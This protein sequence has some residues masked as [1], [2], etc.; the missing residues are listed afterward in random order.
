MKNKEKL[1]FIIFCSYLILILSVSSY[2]SLKI[3]TSDKLSTDKVAHFFEYFVMTVLYFKMRK[4]KGKNLIS[5]KGV[6]F[7]YLFPILDELHQIFIPGRQFSY[8]D[9][10]ANIL[11]VSSII[12]FNNIY[13]RAIGKRTRKENHYAS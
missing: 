8:Y 3:P 10:L 7:L 2:P 5:L 1:Y 13:R 6:I 12:I 9:M 11:G 4:E